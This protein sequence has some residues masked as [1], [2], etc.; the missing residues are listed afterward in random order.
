MI[1]AWGGAAP[2]S[3]QSSLRLARNAYT[4][5]VAP[6]SPPAGTYDPALDAQLGAVGRGLGYTLQGLDTQG[7]RS[8]EDYGQQRHSLTTG[9]DQSLA[10]LLKSH[11]RAGEDFDVTG[12][13][14]GEDYRT[15]G[16]RLGEDHTTNTEA[17]NRN[18]QRLGVS[19][20]GAAIN[21]GVGTQGGSLAAALKARQANQGIDQSAEDRRFGRST[22]DL[23]TGYGRAT[24]DLNTSRSREGEDYGT[25]TG[26]VSSYYDDPTYG[27][28]AQAATQYQRGV[29]DRA[30]EAGRA[31]IE[32]TQFGLDTTAQKNYQAQGAGYVAPAKASNEFSDAKGSYKLVVRGTRRYKVRPDGS[33]EY[34]GTKG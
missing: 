12:Q 17:I 28:L 32:A 6:T 25:Q 7:S 15:S 10:D 20:A 3:L 26:R 1:S 31:G 8:E 9:R 16:T 22:E 33:E 2:N 4:P 18:Y 23:N 21:Q 30:T 13:R 5:Y 34:A 14:L 11:T 19:Q 27:V 29:D 24:T